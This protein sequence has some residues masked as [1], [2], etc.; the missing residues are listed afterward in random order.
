MTAL[1]SLGRRERLFAGVIIAPAILVA[2]AV[3]AVE[4]WRWSRPQA[5]VVTTPFV[6][7]LADAIEADDVER[8]FEFLRAGGDANEFI[9]VRHP[10]L[11]NGRSV[12]AS[13]LVWAVA[14]QR[15]NV[16][17][18]LLGFGARL[19]RGPDRAASCLADA[20]GNADIAEILRRYKEVLRRD[21][22]PAPRAGEAP[23][24]GFIDG[25]KAG[26]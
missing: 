21:Q 7:S 14:T 9:T 18:M 23:L 13:P 16:V 19:D 10:M 22:C 24:V 26:A 8:A 3:C 20:L 1:G 2:L 11:T 12:L 17:R 5:A 6:Y 4:A 25:A 15:L